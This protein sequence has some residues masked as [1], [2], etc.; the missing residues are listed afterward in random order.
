MKINK[1][2]IEHIYEYEKKTW[3]LLQYRHKQ[4]NSFQEEINMSKSIQFL[5]SHQGFSV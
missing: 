5:A 1:N 2:A 3:K 4:N